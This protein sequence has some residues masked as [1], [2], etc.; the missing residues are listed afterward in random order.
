M[1]IVRVATC[2]GGVYVRNAAVTKYCPSMGTSSPAGTQGINTI[3]KEINVSTHDI[4]TPKIDPFFDFSERT[5]EQAK[6][7]PSNNISKCQ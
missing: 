7:A 4:T 6:A 1:T 2:A 5:T 3:A